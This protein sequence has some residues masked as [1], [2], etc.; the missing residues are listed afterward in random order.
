M[1]APVSFK[2]SGNYMEDTRFGHDRY[3]MVQKLMSIGKKYYIKDPDG[4]DVFYARMEKFKLKPKIFIYS[5]ESMAETL[6]VIA[7]R[8][9]LDFNATYDV[10]DAHGDVLIGSLKREG[11]QSLFQNKWNI[12]DAGGNVVGYARESAGRAILRRL[13]IGWKLDFEITYGGRHIGSLRKAISIGDRYTLDLSG[14][15]EK[16]L[17]RR[18]AVAM[19]PLLDAGEDR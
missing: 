6:L 1:P 19:L 14:D 7:P 2:P 15:P 10:M 12:L 13:V 11:V 17:D 8:N 18:L 5:D 3:A 4:N 16:K 9:I